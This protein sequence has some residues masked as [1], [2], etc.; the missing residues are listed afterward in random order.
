MVAGGAAGAPVGTWTV[1]FTDQVGST[2]MRVRVGEEAF[3]GIR[4]DLDAGVATALTAHG[5]V[6]TKLTGDGVMGGFTSTA[7]ALRCAVAIQ[8]A[9]VER[10]RTAREGVAGSEAPALRIGISVGDAVMEDGDLHGTAV[11]EAARLCAAATGGTILCSET[12]SVVSSNRSGCSFGPLRAMDLKGLPGP[13]QA[14]EVTWEPLP[15]EPGEHRLA[16]R[17]LGPLEVLDGDRPVAVGG[18]KERLVLALL[19]ARVNSPVSVDALVEAVWGGRPPRTAER[20]V[21]AYVAR[22]RRTLE[23]RRPP[24]EPSTVLVTVGRGYELRLNAAQL[25]AAR[26]TELA[27]RGSDQLVSGDD[28]AASTLRQALGLWRGEAFREFGE[29]EACVAESRGLEELRLALVEDRVDADL[30]A[31]QSTELVGEIETLLRHEPF[32]ERLWG[33]L[34]LALYR[35]GRQRDA[36]EAYQR[37]R[38]LLADELGIEPGPE[39]RRLEAAV[40]AQDPS[41]DVL[42][43]V[44]AAAPGGLPAAL[45]AV[46]PAFLGRETEL[47]WLR[48]AW[49]GAVDGRG[50]F[51]SVLGPEGIGKTR[52]VAELAREVHDEGAAV[53][54]GRCDHAHRGA[55]ALLGQALQSA[56]SSLGHV[57]GGADDAGD[58]AEALARHLPTW[59]QGRPVLVV[60]DDLHLAD[61]ETLEVVA[62]LAGWCRA[63]PML[64]VGTFRSDAVQPTNPAEPPGS[65]AS[66]LTLGPL[67]GDAVGRICELYA[68]EPWSAE[69]VDRVHELTGGVPL[70][71]HEQA[72]E[73]ARER[74]SR[75]ITGASDRMAVSRGRLVASRGEIADGVEGIQRLLEQRRAQ[76]AGREAQLQ[77]STVAALGGCPYKGLAR[78]E[79]ADAANFFGRERLV[80]ELVARLA[81]SRLLAVVGPSGSGKSSLVRAGLLPA[82]AAGVLPAGRR[83]CS[84]VLCPGPHPA[85]EL[86]QRLQGDWPADGPRVVFVDQFEETFAAGVDRREREE[87]IGRLLDFAAQRDTAVVLAIRADHLGQC[88]SHAALADRLAGNDVLVGPLADSEL[89]R[90]VE[91]FVR[92]TSFLPGGR[93]WHGVRRRPRASDHSRAAAVAV[94][95]AHRSRR[96][97]GHEPL[98]GGGAATRSGLRHAGMPSLTPGHG[99]PATPRAGARR[100]ARPRRQASHGRT[101]TARPPQPRSPSPLRRDDPHP[102]MRRPLHPTR[103]AT[104]AD[105]QQPDRDS[106]PRRRRA[107]HR[108][109]RR[110]RAPGA[111]APRRSR[112]SHTGGHARLVVRGRR[113]HG[114]ARAGPGLA[115]PSLGIRRGNRHRRLARPVI[116]CGREPKTPGQQHEPLAGPGVP[117]ERTTGP[118]PAT[119]TLARPAAIGAVR[120]H[121]SLVGGLASLGA[122]ARRHNSGHKIAEIRRP[123]QSVLPHPGDFCR[124]REVVGEVE[125]LGG[126]LASRSSS[127]P[128]WSMMLR[129]RRLNARSFRRR[130]QNRPSQGVACLRA[131]RVR[132]DRSHDPRSARV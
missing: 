59:S 121:L 21:H 101:D 36:L 13:V 89:R 25:D 40:L 88:A 87:F 74:A 69:D 107:A 51:V 33:Q 35:S 60:L 17:V 81:E 84:A 108:P 42:R 73:W 76:L 104:G 102:A 86:A 16:F 37:A 5:V 32:R 22:L 75:R 63:T 4:A 62:D 132:G 116:P 120:D 112:A 67:S 53:L 47:G 29:V 55:R 113:R 82:L 6:V 99:R 24:G 44:P 28:A 95:R 12:V 127:S 66:Q 91:L 34:M 114:A 70:L 20:T 7:A 111:R 3:D 129:S 9:V 43:P 68:T 124:D 41:L 125:V 18:P 1:L 65:T 93:L 105:H 26:F 128:S 109:A 11:V 83:W 103:S 46:G 119:L 2:A 48:E 8:Q 15:Y 61:A 38:R 80:A 92:N 96:V 64:V 52:L 49:A 58:I 122:S 118:E 31:G 30:A 56:G 123:Y 100:G 94:I 27:A 39:L 77:A 97:R 106:T 19:L 10:N 131:R 110:R 79:A 57:N 85:R 71:V 130:W 50:G 23:P 98:S 126:H 45:A 14:H 90:T 54:Y 72:S 78:F 115:D 117:L